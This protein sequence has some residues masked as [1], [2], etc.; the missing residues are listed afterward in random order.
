MGA[1]DIEIRLPDVILDPRTS[2]RSFLFT[3]EDVF[4]IFWST[5]EFICTVTVFS[6]EVQ[7]ALTCSRLLYRGILS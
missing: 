1:D 6:W 5:S 3:Y 4:Q 2:N 7:S